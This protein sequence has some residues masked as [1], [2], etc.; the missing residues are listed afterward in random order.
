VSC[1]R[2]S[3]N[4]IEEP[5]LDSVRHSTLLT[6]GTRTEKVVVFFRGYTNCSQRFRELGQIYG[7]SFFG[8]KNE[9]DK[10]PP[11]NA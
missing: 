2:D 6:H 5:E 8:A 10:Y 4:I 11:L 7:V 3:N 1:P 9:L